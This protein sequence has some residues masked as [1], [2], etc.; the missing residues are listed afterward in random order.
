MNNLLEEEV[1]LKRFLLGDLSEGEQSEVEE[2][3]FSDPKY[4]SQFRAA[5]D[6]LIDEYLY[7]D[8]DGAE[9]ERFE[10]Y[11]LSTPERRESLRVAKALQQYISEN[12]AGESAARADDEDAP[13]PAAKRSL[14][15]ILFG[16]GP[17]LRFAAVAAAV[18]IIVAGV[19]LAVRNVARDEPAPPLKAMKPDAEPSPAQLAQGGPGRD[20]REP[21]PL[22]SP[23]DEANKGDGARNGAGVA[24]PPTPRR[25][26]APTYSFLILPLGQ[27]RG[28]GGETNEV[29]IRSRSG[30]VKLRVPLIEAGGYRS[31]R[32]SLQTDE[33]KE[34]KSWAGLKSS[35]EASGQTVAVVVP[36]RSLERQNYRLTLSGV[37]PDGG[38]RTIST[39]H[40]KVTK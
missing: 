2:R 29:K 40:F 25:S 35:K 34:I 24:K 37:S 7:G 32:V 9:R 4:F 28:E 33:G 27:V 17:F 30:S 19:W 11:F 16:R 1:L 3:L 38:V 26:P 22:P 31:Y 20:T 36:A 39:F 12:E 5:E 10:N 6:D 14:L 15:D 8:L 21:A 23:G 18:L 13:A